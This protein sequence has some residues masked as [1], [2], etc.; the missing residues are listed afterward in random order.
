VPG[1]EDTNGKTV[2]NAA[3]S[4]FTAANAY[5]SVLTAPGAGKSYTSAISI[6]GVGKG[7]C[8]VSGPDTSG[9]TVLTSTSVVPGSFVSVFTGTTGGATNTKLWGVAITA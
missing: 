1:T 4:T 2:G 3:G 9:T 6:G 7:T 8:T 5:C